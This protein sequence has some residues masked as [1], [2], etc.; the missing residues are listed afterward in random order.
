[1]PRALVYGDVDLN[2]LDGSA[3]WLQSVSQALATAGCDVTLLLKAPI[4]TE[5]LLE[6]LRPLERGHHPQPARGEAARRRSRGEPLGGDRGG[7]ARSA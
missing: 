7:H 2:L 3:I 5:R 4:R 6:P 1:M